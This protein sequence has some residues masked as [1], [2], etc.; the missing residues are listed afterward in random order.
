VVVVIEAKGPTLWF[1]FGGKGAECKRLG[2]Q[3]ECRKTHM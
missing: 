2:F 3:E 1:S